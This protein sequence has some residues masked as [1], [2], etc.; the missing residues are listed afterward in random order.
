[1]IMR[2]KLANRHYQRIQCA[3]HAPIITAWGGG[4][5]RVC[6]MHALDELWHN[7]LDDIVLS[8]WYRR[9]RQ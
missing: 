1:M 3:Q 8:A 9:F 6:I 2:C 4:L 7:Q 5:E